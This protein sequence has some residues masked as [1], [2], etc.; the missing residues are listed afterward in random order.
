VTGLSTGALD[1]ALQIHSSGL[2]G[3]ARRGI[4]AL[5][6]TEGDDKVVVMINRPTKENQIMDETLYLH[7]IDCGEAFDNLRDAFAHGCQR[8][9]P[10]DD[11]TRYRISEEL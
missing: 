3:S 6:P 5:I 1:R 11:E 2:A 10:A 7:C 8:F 9:M 4:R